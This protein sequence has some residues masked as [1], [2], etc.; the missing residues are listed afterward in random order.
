RCRQLL[1]ELRPRQTGDEDLRGFE[2]YYWQHLLQRGYV[3][4][5]GQDIVRNVAYSPDGKRLASGS[6]HGRVRV[7]DAQTGQEVLTL[8]GHTGTV[9]SVCFSP[10]GKCLA[11]ASS[12]KTVRLWDAQSGQEV[13]T[14]RGHTGYV[15]SVCFSPDGTRIASAS[16]DLTV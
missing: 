16:E 11:S 13:L 12:D 7:W 2:W 4:L 6:T 14:L 9:A 1:D 8:R 15:T 10:D 5:H 3:S